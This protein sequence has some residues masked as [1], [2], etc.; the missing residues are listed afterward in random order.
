MLHKFCITTLFHSRFPF[1][2]IFFSLSPI[3]VH[4]FTSQDRDG[5]EHSPPGSVSKWNGPRKAPAALEM[6]P[7]SLDIYVII[8]PV[9]SAP[10][11]SWERLERFPLFFFTTNVLGVVQ[12]RIN[13][14]QKCSEATQLKDRSSVRKDSR[15]GTLWD[16]QIP[17]FFFIWRSHYI[18]MFR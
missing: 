9:E 10:Y 1:K 17:V 15:T 7:F 4:A 8:V 16:D 5:W 3:I 11:T 14:S 18:G 12:E 2:Q 6:G 13:S